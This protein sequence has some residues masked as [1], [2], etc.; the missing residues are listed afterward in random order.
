[1]FIILTK[2][3]EKYSRLPY[4]L[5]LLLAVS[6]S[7][8]SQNF[9]PVDS[10]FLTSVSEEEKNNHQTF[11][12]TKLDTS[13]NNFNNYL[14][15]NSN[16]YLGMPSSPFLF[17]YQPQTLGFQLF[18]LPY[19]NDIIT[20]N[21]IRYYQT[22][23][24]F[25]SLTGIA[26]SKQEQVFK[27]LFSQ[28]FRNKLNITVAFNR[29]SGNGFYLKQQSFTNNFY[30]SSNYK[31]KNER[32]GYDTY[33]LFNK[34]KHQENGGVRN[35][36][37]LY[38]NPAI[39]KQL[40]TVN[41]SNAKREFKDL[42]INGHFWY[43]LNK[44][45]SNSVF[46]HYIHYTA[47][48]A[49]FHTKY[50]DAG[51]YT[52]KYYQ[53]YYLD[54]A[55][56]KDST[57]WRQ[58]TNDIHYTI[59]HNALKLSLDIGY[60]NEY[61]QL[62]Q[63]ANYD[64]KNNLV[65]A[66]LF[67]NRARYLGCIKA[68]YIFN[69]YNQTDYLLEFKNKFLLTQL[70]KYDTKREPLLINLNISQEQRHPDYIYTQWFSNHY[71]WA[72]Q[73]LPTQKTQALLS[74][75][76]PNQTEEMGIILQNI[77]H[78]LY[79][80][81]QAIPAQANNNTQNLHAFFKTQSLFFKHLGI[82]AQYNFQKS[83]YQ[84]ITSL[85][86]HTINSAIYYQGNLFKKALQL[87]LGFNATYYSSFNGLAYMPATNIYY[88]QTQQSQGDYTFIDF[89][90]NARIKPVRFFVKLEHLN[91][92]FMGSRYSLTP[93]YWQSDRAIKFGLNWLFFD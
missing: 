22:K 66:G 85:P 9:Y 21:N 18:Q 14:S 25:A 6:T 69:G 10:T 87:Q 52:D 73:F 51:I 75:A 72:N 53:A 31:S 32:I 77:S 30:V 24:P 44:P 93:H 17:Q 12:K 2:I 5:L 29:Y 68:D 50:N 35:D 26:G 59:Q 55:T 84:A 1:M 8:Y 46:S 15:R 3:A 11:S 36:S 74:I 60:K 71:Q 45:D 40:L 7:V 20:S 81:E 83:T 91:Q 27:F 92:G 61:N 56:T 28:T 54:T 90:M 4:Y 82:N 86:N 58:L 13:I 64:F 43:R 63:Y 34:L 38:Q 41:L 47:H 42:Q 49:G 62:Y 76:L 23:G 78:T 16:G 67:L 19:K 79:F 33:L 65:Y 37:L 89:F 48:Y 57:H 70:G 39:S 88:T 80:N